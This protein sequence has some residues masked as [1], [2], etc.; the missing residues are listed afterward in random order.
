MSLRTHYLETPNRS[1]NPGNYNE[2]LKAY[3]NSRVLEYS[4]DNNYSPLDL[5]D[6]AREVLKVI[7]SKKN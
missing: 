4:A 7:K 1:E 2:D 3:E 5:T 6:K